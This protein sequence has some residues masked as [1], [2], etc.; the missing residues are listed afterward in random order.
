MEFL[1]DDVTDDRDAPA[2]P[3]KTKRKA[4]MHELQALGE[5]LVRLASD[6]LAEVPIPD[7]LREA[8]RDAAAMTRGEGRRRQ[9]QYIG[10]LMREVDPAPIRAKLA[11]WHGQSVD[12]TRAHHLIERWRERL[13]EEEGALTEFCRAYVVADVQA[14]RNCIREARKEQAAIRAARVHDPRA[15]AP[16]ARRYRELFQQ[17][18]RAL[19]APPNVIATEEDP[20]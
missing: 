8:V 4:A 7:V 6:R 16:P 18:R 14:L 5:E 2:R 1:I 10:R 19:D 9:L 11:A 13:I 20:S 17:V 12:A 3:S 15:A